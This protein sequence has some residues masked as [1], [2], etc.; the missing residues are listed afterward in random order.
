MPMDVDRALQRRLL[1]FS[2]IVCRRC[3]KKGHLQKDCYAKIAVIEEDD[4][5]SYQIISFLEDL[6]S[7]DESVPALV[8]AEE[9]PSMDF[10]QGRK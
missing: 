1:D 8:S 10:T 5:G 4:Q 9:P 7:I 6:E 2:N 3:G